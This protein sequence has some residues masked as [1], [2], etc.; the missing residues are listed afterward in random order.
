MFLVFW[1]FFICVILESCKEIC[2]I[3]IEIS[4]QTFLI[5]K[6]GVMN[7]DVQV[8]INFLQVGPCLFILLL[9]VMT[10]IAVYV[11]MSH[12]PVGKA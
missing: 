11:K 4:V 8:T 9:Y 7:K 3:I 2:R 12:P 1:G 5:C 10:H 6:E